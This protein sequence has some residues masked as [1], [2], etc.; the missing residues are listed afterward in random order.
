MGG[1]IFEIFFGF[2]SSYAVVKPH[3]LH[4]LVIKNLMVEEFLLYFIILF[5]CVL[6]LPQPPT[7][8]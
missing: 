3:L 8:L 2:K 1:P 4:L 5:V 6:S 7:P